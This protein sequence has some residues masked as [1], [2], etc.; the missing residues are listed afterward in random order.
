MTIQEMEW[1]NTP[2]PYIQY[3]HNPD[4]RL[5]KIIEVYGFCFDDIYWYWM[6]KYRR[7]HII[8]GIVKKA[9]L[10]TYPSKCINAEKANPKNKRVYRKYGK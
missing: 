8:V 9:P 6:P 3:T 2:N 4:I 10:W 7:S 5:I 1:L